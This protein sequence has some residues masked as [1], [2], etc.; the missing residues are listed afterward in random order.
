LKAEVKETS[1]KANRGS[2]MV[3]QD[4]KKREKGRKKHG[5]S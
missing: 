5:L 2:K 4:T 3:P 1:R